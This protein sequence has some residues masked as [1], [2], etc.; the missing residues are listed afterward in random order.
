MR[1]QFLSCALVLF[2]ISLF[3]QVQKSTDDLDFLLGQ[4]Q[5]KRTYSPNTQ[6]ERQYEGTLSCAW[7]MDSTYIE[8]IYVM[9]RPEK[10]R[11]LDQVY[12]NY[13]SIY[14][15]Y[16][17]MWL[18]STWPIKATSKGE[19]VTKGNNLEMSTGAEFPIQDGLTEFV[20]TTWQITW[21]DDHYDIS[22]QTFIRTNKDVEEDWFHHM[23]E[24]LVYQA[25]TK[26]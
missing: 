5:V 3:G 20:K 22:R 17:S 13:N 9:E 1:K 7:A 23:N 26:K 4:W 10:K 8:C 11:G 12:F 2:A 15:Q 24:T 25:T 14:D 21:V 18:S 16:E 19:L 6:K